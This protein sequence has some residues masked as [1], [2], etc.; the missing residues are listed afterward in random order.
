MKY[1]D[2][3]SASGMGKSKDTVS[4]QIVHTINAMS[5]LFYE[6]ILIADVNTGNIVY[7]SINSQLN[8]RLA[9]YQL[10]KRT[11]QYFVETIAPEHI[12]QFRAILSIIKD[13]YG[14]TVTE[15]RNN[16][17]YTTDLH[18]TLNDKHEMATFRMSPLVE[19]ED[20]NLSQMIFAI[21]FSATK[22]KGIIMET[23]IER[24]QRRIF[25]LMVGEWQEFKVPVLTPI[26]TAVL[27]C[28]AQ[29]LSVPE[30]AET[31][32][33]AVDTIKSARKRIFKKL[34]VDNIT[35]A[36]MVAI[37]YKLI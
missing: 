12:G 32:N 26:E 36:I 22:Q 2:F 33:R 3:M 34:K 17:I 8:K 24:S 6:L 10:E 7:L 9:M 29:G 21:G 37:D 25:D 13:S 20:G 30:I 27:S 11:L 5:N 23:N 14:S 28:S 16:I 35:R 18:V 19:D 15:E 31:L 1:F 4:T